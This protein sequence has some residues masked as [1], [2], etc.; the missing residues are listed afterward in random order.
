MFPWKWTKKPEFRRY[1]KNNPTKE[2]IRVS[3]MA[4][5]VFPENL[6]SIGPEI[7][8][9]KSNKVWEKNF[10]MHYILS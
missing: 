8:L 7:D 9:L 3:R 1:F 4:L 6:S 10:W 2:E 5:R